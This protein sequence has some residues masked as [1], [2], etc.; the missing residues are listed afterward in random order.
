MKSFLGKKAVSRT[1]KATLLALS[2]FA[3]I[4]VHLGVG[5]VSLQTVKALSTFNSDPSD[6][7][8]L[9]S[10]NYTQYPDSTNHW[11]S[12]TNANAGD[13]VSLAVYYH[14]SS[15]ETAKNV[16]ISMSMPSTTGSSVAASA[17]LSADNFNTSVGSTTIVLSSNQSLQYIPGSASWYPNQST[18]ATPFPSGQTGDEVVTSGGV[19]IGDVSSGWSTQGSVVARFKV[20]Q[21][22]PP[23]PPNATSTGSTLDITANGSQGPVTLSDGQSFTLNWI[24]SNVTN[25]ALSESDVPFSSGVTSNGSMGPVDPTHP[26]YPPAG[27]SYSFVISCQ[28]VSG[29][30]SDSVVVIHPKPVVQ[31][32]QAPKISN[33][34]T[35]CKGNVTLSWG[36]VSGATSY[37]VFRNGVQIA[38]T[39]ATTITDSNTTPNTQYSYAVKASNS[40]GDSALSDPVT[41]TTPSSCVKPPMAPTIW[42][43]AGSSCGGN[44]FVSWNAV[45]NATSYNVYRDGTL[46]ATSSSLSFTDKGLSQGVTY[47]YTVQAV[48]SAGTSPFSNTA[49]TKASGVCATV[50]AAPTLAATTGTQC[51]GT[52]SLTWNSVT[53]ADSYKIFR[54]GNQIATTTNTSFVDSGLTPLSSHYYKVTAVNVVGDSAYSNNVSATASAE[55]P[56]PAPT[57]SLNANPTTITKGDSSLLTWN[58]TNATSCN[59][60]WTSAT[61]TSGSES[62]SP[63]T[64]TAYSINCT[65]GTANTTAS[66]TVTVNPAPVQTPN[67]WLVANPTKI[68]KGQ[69]STLSW[70]SINATNCSALW[71]TSTSTS[72]SQVVSPT[73]T[74]SYTITCS[75]ASKTATST[76][77]VTVC[78]NTPVC[79]EPTITSSLTATGT[80]GQA[81]SYTIV[82]SSSAT[83]TLSYSVATSSLP[84]G[85]TFAG[86]TISGTPIH[87][88]T[89]TVSISAT[90]SCG[91]TSKNLVITI[92]SG[93]GG[94]GITPT[95]NLTAN[96]ST[97]SAG[98]NSTLL[99]LLVVSWSVRLPLLPMQ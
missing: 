13:T 72:G 25:C 54:D 58:S 75:N 22:L 93:G 4:S 40:A 14:N 84:D 35:D 19:N 23:P 18:T 68:S 15:Q 62:V 87:S 65:N 90:N 92:S 79:V 74:T 67:V 55:C 71:T 96:P 46:V 5:G 31:I 50:P 10:S 7:A 59:A 61:S 1:I 45:Q 43:V 3:I 39:S 36:A 51:G 49:S 37:K 38:S 12:V 16:R 33:I 60:L 44:V 88:G 76:A 57:V 53:N 56:L 24:S 70:T 52:I 11:A 48:N 28:G 29:P 66:T 34:D 30:I 32:P 86:N 77:T 98:A 8:T 91:T 47:S 95:L 9:R 27:A 89:Y 99:P 2:L 82:A 81:F 97:I 73:S 41:I 42:A 85:L 26:Y 78:S 69:N 64:T 20:S 80:V 21:N 83:T 94:G 17:T 63:A 6:Y